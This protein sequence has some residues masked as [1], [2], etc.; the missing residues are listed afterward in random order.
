M[1]AIAHDAARLEIELSRRA[2]EQ[3]REELRS[4]LHHD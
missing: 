4:H 1:D 2:D 3:K